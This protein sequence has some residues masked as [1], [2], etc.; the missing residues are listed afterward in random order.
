[1][2]NDYEKLFDDLTVEKA[3]IDKL[4]TKHWHISCAE[5][6][7]G[8]MIISRLIGVSGASDV[9]SE[10]HITYSVE[11]KNKWLGVP[12]EVIQKDGVVSEN[13]A[14]MMV[15]GVSKLSGAEV[16]VSVT[17]YAGRDTEERMRDDG[18]CYF[19]IK[20]NDDVYVSHYHAEGNRNA[21]RIHQ[22]AHIL[23]T[24]YNYLK[25]L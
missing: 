7:T 3:I 14:R 25:E 12:F 18:L 22:S 17:G 1:M 9:I 16:S 5:S 19:G 21:S 24:L 6:C 10:S 8:G 20:I 4:K 11:A 13:T 23:K 15:I 2:N